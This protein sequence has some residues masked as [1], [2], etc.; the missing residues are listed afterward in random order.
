MKFEEVY[1]APVY[2]KSGRNFFVVQSGDTHQTVELYKTIIDFRQEEVP[3][4]GTFA[5]NS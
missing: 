2:A 4:D 1:I 5:K 3:G